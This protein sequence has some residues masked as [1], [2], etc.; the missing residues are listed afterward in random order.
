MNDS[1]SYR[2]VLI[3]DNPFVA[4]SSGN[5]LI[6]RTGNQRS[7]RPLFVHKIAPCRSACPIGI[8][9]PAA[10]YEAS[11]GHL[12][13]ALRIYLEDNPLPGISGRVCYHPC[14]GQC[15]RGEFDEP[16]NVRAFERFLADHATAD[17]T[18]LPLSSRKEKVAV[19]GSGPS[20]LSCA[21]HLARKG[22][23]V[24]IFEQRAE[25][26]G[27]L[28]YGIPPYRLPREVLDRE[29]ARIL[30]LG[31]TLRC[32]A[33]ACDLDAFDA[34]FYGIGLQK[35][36]PLFDDP[37]V[38]SGLAFLAD[39]HGW[40]LDEPKE[41][42]LVIGGGNVGID[43]ARTLV[44]IRAGS[45]KNIILLSPESASQMPALPEEVSEARDEGIT[46]MN[47][48]APSG[49]TR[50]G[51]RL[52]L[53]TRRVEVTTDA[54]GMITISP[55]G[56][57]IE[58][59]RADR[60]IVAIG[61]ELDFPHPPA[62]K[63]RVIADPFCG[64]SPRMFAGGDA[65]GNRAFV[66]DAIASGKMAALSIASTLEGKVI[67]DEYSCR[68][69]GTGT[70]F[71]LRAT[72]ADLQSVVPFERINTLFFTEDSRSNPDLLSPA[73]RKATFDEVTSG[74]DP[75]S[76]DREIARCFKCGTCIDCKH[77]LDFC[78]DISIL[79]DPSG[80]IFDYDHCKGC[81][82]CDT[83]CPR[84]VIEMVKEP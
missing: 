25:P 71:S 24:T 69:L 7:E 75:S 66:A 74:L 47:G 10:F 19:I 18:H 33:G 12:D 76:M 60:V 23:T 61:Q 48:L 62:Q 1:R 49:L 16:I 68:R 56:D 26:G 59:F 55:I 84:N 36:K 57:E 80:L 72:D 15:N 50:K 39:P 42:V 4:M 3:R 65:T 27:M 67:E 51:R 41:K 43:V 17:L 37:S 22:Y 20:G 38:L 52:H 21:Y 44:R 5:S 40:S 70:A 82:M 34:V 83:V 2:P 73:V 11:Q 9:I 14:E 79:K 54:E 8:D 45:A 77:C 58:R 28:R 78:P 46:I 53:E 64:I 29:I 13:E 32:C 35:G 81:G 6:F 63:G 31:I 30:A